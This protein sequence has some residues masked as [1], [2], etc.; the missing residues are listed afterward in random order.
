MTRPVAGAE[1]ER[2]ITALAARYEA[3]MTIQQIADATRRS[4][5]GVHKLLT[6]GGVVFRTSSSTVP[7]EVVRE[8][9]RRYEAG[10][11]IRAIA[12]VT[13]RPYTTVR[14]VLVAQR[15]QLRPRGNQRGA[16]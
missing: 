4:Y 5:S 2:F 14:N 8:V 3:G 16:W 10:D 7:R 6:E 11:S 12:A 1:R 15:V 13:G 9:V